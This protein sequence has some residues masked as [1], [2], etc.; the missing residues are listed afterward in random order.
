[1]NNLAELNREV[2]VLISG[3]HGIECRTLFLGEVERLVVINET[4]T[5]CRSVRVTSVSHIGRGLDYEILYSSYRN[6]N[7]N[8]DTDG[9]CVANLEVALRIIRQWVVDRAPWDEVAEFS[10]NQKE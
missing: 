4:G 8:D 6:W 1:M 5:P 3:I 7:S 10:V 2:C 9:R